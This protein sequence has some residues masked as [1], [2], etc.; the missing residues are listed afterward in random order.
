MIFTE[1]PMEAIARKWRDDGLMSGNHQATNALRLMFVEAFQTGK[2]PS[3]LSR[4]LRTSL[5]NGKGKRFDGRGSNDKIYEAILARISRF[6]KEWESGKYEHLLNTK[7]LDQ[8][9]KK[10]RREYHK[11]NNSKSVNAGARGSVVLEEDN[12]VEEKLITELR[13]LWDKDRRVSRTIIFR[14]ALEIDPLFKVS[15]GQG[16]K[17]SAEHLSRLKQ[18]FYFRF[19]K[20]YR[21]SNRKIASVGQKLPRGWQRLLEKQIKRIAAAQLPQRITLKNGEI[22]NVP[23][24]DDDVFF[25]FDHVPVWQETVGTTTWGE[26]DSGRRNVK[27]AGKEKN[28]YTVVLGIS[29]EKK[30]L[31][32]F[33]IFKGML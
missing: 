7:P 30:K 24:I 28:R 32:P 26:K 15:G 17:G 14:L 5:Y 12:E 1:S 9:S 27:T 31:P 4:F 18:W 2:T 22:A 29:K 16:G 6:K 20:K 11:N 3:E 8:M 25:N 13:A 10:E 23:G 21:L 19:N 33:I